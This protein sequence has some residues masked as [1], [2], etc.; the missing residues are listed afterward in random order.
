MTFTWE[1][2]PWQRDE[3]CTH[4]AVTLT[5]VGDGQIALNSESVRGENAVEALSDL[6]M[7]PGGAGGMVPLSGLSGVVVKR[8]I[9][10]MWMAQPPIQVAAN[11]EGG[12]DIAVQG[13]DQLDVTAFSAEHT[14]ELL[15]RLQ[16]EYGSR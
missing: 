16:A 12:W 10:V 4:M 13:G 14:R 1:V 9:D 15:R 6:L 7:G 11:A 2:P 5:D 3:N 8:G